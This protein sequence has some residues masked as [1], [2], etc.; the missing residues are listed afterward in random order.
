MK[1]AHEIARQELPGYI[2]DSDTSDGFDRTDLVDF[3]VVAI[4]ADRRQHDLIAAVAE[5]LD[6]RGAH[7]AAQLVRDTDPD[8]DLW[9]NYLGPMLDQLQTDYSISAAELERTES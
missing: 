6:D 5:A 1:S 8:D 7:R 9:R 3:A 4:E 2:G